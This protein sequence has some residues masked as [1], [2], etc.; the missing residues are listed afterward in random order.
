[1]LKNKIKVMIEKNEDGGRLITCSLLVKKQLYVS[2]CTKE[3]EA[4]MVD[5]LKENIIKELRAGAV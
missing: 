3:E 1:M 4:D 2:G 5:T